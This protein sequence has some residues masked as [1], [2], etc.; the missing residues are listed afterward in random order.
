MNDVLLIFSQN[1][2]H[3]VLSPQ[4]LIHTIHHHH[5]LSL[6]PSR[7]GLSFKN[8]N[9]YYLEVSQCIISLLTAPFQTLRVPTAHWL[10]YNCSTYMHHLISVYVSKVISI[11]LSLGSLTLGHFDLPISQTP[12]YWGTWR[13]YSCLCWKNAPHN[14]FPYN[15]LL[16]S[17]QPQH[18]CHI[19]W[20]YYYP[21][22]YLPTFSKHFFLFV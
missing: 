11:H 8:N 17:F 3:G 20:K 7:F 15:R 4:F 9:I 12:E 16:E 18:K 19:L 2:T 1:P 5:S 22:F 13:M 6:L 10:K 14:L 21:K